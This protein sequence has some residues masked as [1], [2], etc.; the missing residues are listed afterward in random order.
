MLPPDR[1]FYD[2]LPAIRG[3][4]RTYNLDRRTYGISAEK[5]D[6][7]SLTLKY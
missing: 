5:S 4:L 2:H 7:H 1:H 6:L 3:S